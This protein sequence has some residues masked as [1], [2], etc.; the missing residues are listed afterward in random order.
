MLYYFIDCIGLSVLSFIENIGS[1][2]LFFLDFFKALFL[3]KLRLRKLLEQM[4]FI[5]V[6]S[7]LIVVLTGTFTGMVFTIQC[8]VGFQRFGGEQFIGAIVAHGLIREL[9]PVLTGLI[10]TG[11]AG[12]AVA[13]E[14]GTMNI[15]EQIDALKMLQINTFQ[16]LVVPRVVAGMITLP[17][18]ATCAMFCGIVG[19][20]VV[21]VYILQLNPTDYTD[22]IQS[23]IEIS[24]IV[25]GLVKSF[26]FGFTLSIV[27][28]YKGYFARNGA[29]GVG[30]SATQAVVAASIVI[31]MS[32][33]FLTKMLEQL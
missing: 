4:S 10:V 17:L 24:D 7:L 26:F 6:D 33:Y 23:F 29:R 27:G 13:A 30:Q 5:G 19:G 1:F 20:Y 22:S 8:F 25:S 32:N 11:R 2:T 9:G 15:T 21:S 16:Y 3:T 18:L 28:A 14:L 12:S 31:L